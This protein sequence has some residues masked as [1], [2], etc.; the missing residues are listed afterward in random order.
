VITAA[1][2][3]A[4]GRTEQFI[5]IVERHNP[6]QTLARRIAIPL[7]CLGRGVGAAMRRL[8]HSHC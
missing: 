8:F 7:Q 4:V 6:G 2:G 3:N 5:E 1:D